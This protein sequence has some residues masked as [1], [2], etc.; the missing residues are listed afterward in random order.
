MT[1]SARGLPGTRGT[2]SFR[3]LAGCAEFQPSC[4]LRT[5][6]VARATPKNRFLL[7][8]DPSRITLIGDSAG[9]N[10]AAALSLMARDASNSSAAADP[11][12]PP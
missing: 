8:V 2:T 6:A 3:R 4:G 1:G 9:G 11:D 5:A 12:L 10:L 7:N